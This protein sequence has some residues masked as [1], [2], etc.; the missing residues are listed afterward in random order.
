MSTD[1]PVGKRP[2]PTESRVPV[3]GALPALFQSLVQGSPLVGDL[4]EAGTF[5]HGRLRAPEQAIHV[6]VDQKL[7]HLCEDAMAILLNDSPDYD[8]LAR[9][10]QIQ[11]RAGNTIGELD[12]LL[13]DLQSGQLIHLELAT[14][15]YLAVET[16]TGL[17][18]PG[19]DPRDNYFKK[20]RRLRD[21]QLSLSRKHRD[22][23]PEIYRQ[24]PITALQLVHG[25]LFDHVDAVQPATAE[26]IAPRCRRGRW[27]TI[28]E[29][30]DHFPDG[31]RVEIIPKHLWPVPLALLN[32]IRLDAWTPRATIDRC[33]MLR[34]NDQPAPCFV[35]PLR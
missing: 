33:V 5:P 23:L 24:E 15:F 32:N 35:V 9:N 19:P 25:C 6:N 1:A 17:T 18:L 26:F 8:L 31:S 16:D 34:V 7:G 27:L 2:D 22:L 12:F 10:L 30:P 4:P 29:Y 11:D 28:A 21:H 3:P 20:L 13:R 14:K